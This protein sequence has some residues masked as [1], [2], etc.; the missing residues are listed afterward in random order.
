MDDWIRYTNK[1]DFPST[2]YPYLTD[3]FLALSD[4]FKK[5][6]RNR[7]IKKIIGIYPKIRK[8]KII[9]A[10]SRK[11]R[12]PS[13]IEFPVFCTNKTAY[14]TIKEVAPV[15]TK[16][17]MKTSIFP[18]ITPYPVKIWEYLDDVMPEYIIKSFE[19]RG[20]LLYDIEG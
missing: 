10:S 11:G 7:T 14:A 12:I 15:L 8:T 20:A 4:D 17:Y 9:R 13:E 5:K 19:T 3:H 18:I 6:K 2:E 16:F 1:D